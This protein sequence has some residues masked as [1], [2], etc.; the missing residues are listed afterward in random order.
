MSSDV[1]ITSCACVVGRLVAGRSCWRKAFTLIE[2][3]VV[4]GSMA[5]LAGILVPAVGR[6]KQHARKLLNMNNQR[7]IVT[8]ATEYS[9]QHDERFPPSVAMLIAK[10]TFEFLGWDEPRTMTACWPLNRSGARSISR[11]L[12]PYLESSNTMYCPNAPKSKVFQREAWE[13]GDEWDHPTAAPHRTSDPV[14]GTYCFY[15][16]YRGFI[17][18]TK[19]AFAG[20]RDSAAGFSSSTVMLTDYFGYGHPLNDYA[21]GTC[22]AYGSCELLPE[23]GVTPGSPSSSD[24]WSIEDRYKSITPDMIDVDLYAAYTDGHVEKYTPSE[25]TEMRVSESYD[26]MRP[27]PISMS[28]GT[29]YLPRKAVPGLAPP[30]PYPS[31]K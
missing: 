19:R 10:D 28:P 8:A 2:L 14:F 21:Y 6:V 11:F 24:F 20:P 22:R 18:E 29:F 12:R 7:Q 13:A 31:P 9:I 15:W 4:I 5:L 17:T 25:A 3:L 1:V 26:G 16:N 27:Q 23:G 30:N